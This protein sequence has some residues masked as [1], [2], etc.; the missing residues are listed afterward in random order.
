M[1]D[2]DPKLKEE[3]KRYSELRQ[4]VQTFSRKIVELEAEL[5]EHNLLLD[6]I[7]P[8][9]A[10]RKCWRMISGILVE[11][12]IGEV[13]PAIEQNRTGITM[14]VNDMKKQVEKQEKDIAEFEKKH[15]DLLRESN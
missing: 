4:N 8:F 13:I 2:I 14:V 12:T 6:T 10:E 15:A 9:N 3:L 7:R 1:A 5:N 11:H